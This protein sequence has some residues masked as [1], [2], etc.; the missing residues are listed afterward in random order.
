MVPWAA[1]L[2]SN[3]AALTVIGIEIKGNPSGNHKS[4]QDTHITS[5]IGTGWL[6]TQ[7]H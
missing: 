7:I 4:C 2:V 1:Q 3:G 5:G 6:P